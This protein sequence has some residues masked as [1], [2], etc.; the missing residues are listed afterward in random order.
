MFFIDKIMFDLY[1]CINSTKHCEI[2]KIL[3]Y[4]SK[5]KLVTF[6]NAIMNAILH[7]SGR[8]QVLM[9]KHVICLVQGN[10]HKDRALTTVVVFELC[11]I[12]RYLSSSSISSFN[13]R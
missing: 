12:F 7:D 10:E 8:R 2:K 13:H 5:Y 9:I 1:Y 4:Y 6:S 11:H 3:A